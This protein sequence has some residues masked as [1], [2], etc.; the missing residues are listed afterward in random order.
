MTRKPARFTW[1]KSSN[2]TDNV[3]ADQFGLIKNQ[4]RRMSPEVRHS[5]EYLNGVNPASQLRQK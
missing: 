4:I 3:N 5:V 1:E 2:L